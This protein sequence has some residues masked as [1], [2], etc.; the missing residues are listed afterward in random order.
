[1]GTAAPR[2]G[3]E[4]TQDRKSHTATWFNASTCQGLALHQDFAQTLWEQTQA[5]G[6]PVHRLRRGLFQAW[7]TVSQITQHAQLEQPS[8][9][10]AQVRG[11]QVMSLPK[12]VASH[13]GEM[14][15][16]TQPEAPA[17]LQPA[18]KRRALICVLYLQR[19]SRTIAGSLPG[20]GEEEPT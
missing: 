10:S 14:A 11:L 2:P 6:T 15:G 8:P 4:V 5:L 9:N 1:M 19:A 7:G 3:L 20:G 18:P 12:A 16:A 13:A 17:V